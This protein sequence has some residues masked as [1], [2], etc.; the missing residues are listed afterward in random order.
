MASN[1]LQAWIFVRLSFRKSLGC[2]HNCD[3]HS[4][5]HSFTHIEICA[6]NAVHFQTKLW[7]QDLE[8]T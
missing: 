3:G 5:I 1:P 8:D 7:Q 6:S 4:L 2:A